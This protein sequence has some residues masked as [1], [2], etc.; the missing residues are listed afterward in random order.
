MGGRAG[1]LDLG[2]LDKR[3]RV[4]VR[5]RA[6][7]AGGRPGAEEEDLSGV[8]REVLSAVASA[9]E[10]IE[11]ARAGLARACEQRLRRLA[12][13]PADFEGPFTQARL[14]LRQ[15]EGRAGPD[16][17][18]ARARAARAREELDG[19]RRT[20]RLRHAAN[21]PDSP[22]LQG[23][24]LLAAAG[25]EAVFSATLFAETDARGLL[26]GAATALGLSGANVAL[27]F[28]AGFLGLRYTHHVALGRR[29]AGY[30][31]FVFFLG[32]AL[33]LNTFAAVWRD[34]I[35][36]LE[37]G[38]IARLDEARLFGLAEPQAVILLML[39]AGAW[40]FAAL[41]GYSGFDEPYPDYGKMA[42]AK[43]GAEEALSEQRALTRGALEEALDTAQAAIADA[44]ESA[45][46]AVRAMR[47]AY[48]EA[49]GESVDL[50]SAARSAAEA[51]NAAIALYRRENRAARTGPPPP[52]FDD[53]L[54]PPP[55]PPDAL[56]RAAG[57]V[58]A[59][60]AALVEA[61]SL[62]AARL[63]ARSQE[64]E[65]ISARLE[66]GGTEA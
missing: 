36:A 16:F 57:L 3:L 56:A 37:A 27:G 59:A 19:F 43:E 23:A 15:I 60:E 50:D 65:S 9:L 34:Q 2:V 25:F 55:D 58:L 8:E 52:Y 30:G 22:I 21:Y 11:A 24:L 12:P 5:A 26:G 48:D 35:G 17:A 49:A 44:L 54:P 4:R 33:A 31:A 46:E 39:G 66:Q 47:E 7:A 53:P 62:A 51:G 61:Q 14:A 64:L 38:P 29:L 10:R 1:E 28:L 6:D 32:L 40:V 45:R 41:K 13:P 42:R 20:H 63:E 18:L